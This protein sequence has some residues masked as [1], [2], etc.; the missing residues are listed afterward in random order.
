MRPMAPEKK[1]IQD[2][3][4]SDWCGVSGVQANIDRNDK[5][6]LIARY[7]ATA[8]LPVPTHALTIAGKNIR[9]CPASTVRQ[10]LDIPRTD[11]RIII[12]KEHE[13]KKK[14][15]SDRKRNLDCGQATEAHEGMCG[16]TEGTR[17]R[18][19]FSI[20]RH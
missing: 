1:M 20:K 3:T 4:V 16:L 2:I 11:C 17:V 6:D 12:L 7:C 9:L 18:I 5:L 13:S 10:G 8:S 14:R 15:V 19:S